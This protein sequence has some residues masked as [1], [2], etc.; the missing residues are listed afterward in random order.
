T[1][2]TEQESFADG[3]TEEL[4]AHLGRLQPEHLGVIARTSVMSYKHNDKRLEQIGRELSAQYVLEGS[5]RRSADR[6]RLTVQLVRVS[7]QTHL[8]AENYDR[9]THD[10]LEVQDDVARSVARE[11]QLRLTLQEQAELGMHRATDPLAHESYLK[12]RYFWNKRTEQ[13][14]R[15]AI[16]YFQSAIARDPAHAEAYAGLADSYLLLSGYG[17]EPQR[18]AL[19]KAKAA[20]TRAIEIDGMLAEAHTTL[21]L[22]ALQHDWNWSESEMHFKYA[23]ELNPNYSVAH[24]MYGDGYLWSVGKTQEAMTELQRAHELDPLSLIIS[25]DLAKHLC[26]AGKY[27]DG[28]EMLMKVLEADADFVQAHYYL[29]RAYALRKSY[30]AAIA[31]TN[32]IKEPDVIPFGIGQRGYVYALQGKRREAL[33]I[34]EQ[35]QQAA[36]TRNVDPHYI[37]DIYIGLGDKDQ[38]FAWLEK[39]YAEHSP[40][41]IM[42]K[43]D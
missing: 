30:A 26:F 8:W 22:I 2:D 33:E 27:D 16:E 9:G 6:L 12:G 36:K 11:I 34:I 41:I 18:D 38:A 37:A 21:G 17:F 24:E 39:A 23:L 28:M 20:A 35:L 15:K 10:I 32:K 13:G 43:V 7:D 14:F 4:I 1:G 40:G 25:T 3:L 31:E 19:P 29:S 42:L 5:F